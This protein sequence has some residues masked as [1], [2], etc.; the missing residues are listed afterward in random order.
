MQITRAP[1][2]AT[3]THSTTPMGAAGVW[4]NGVPAFNALDGGSYRTS[5]NADV[6]GGPVTSTAVHWSAAS[7]EGGPVTAGSLVSAF[8]NFDSVLATST[9]AAASANWPTSL[10]GATVSIVDSAGVTF[11]AP[12]FYASPTQLNYRVPPNVAT[13]VATVRI[14]ANGIV[15]P[16]GINI[17]PTYPGLFRV[18]VEGLAAAQVARLRNGQVVYESASGPISLTDSP[19]LVLFS[20][21]LNGA[22]DVSATI[23]GLTAAVDYAGPQGT[24]AGLEQINVKIPAALAGKGKVEIVVTA[25]GKR[26]NPVFISIQ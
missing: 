10:G 7:L 5:A 9:E 25:G 24:W 20:T 16:G 13:G 3:A 22:S 6:G 11:S 19:T 8:A 17:V 12:I 4:V 15:V 1:Q 26:S 14:S 2:P 23:G 21:G 18:N